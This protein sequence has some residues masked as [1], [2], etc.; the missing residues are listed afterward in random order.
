MTSLF[1]PDNSDQPPEPLMAV[2]PSDGLSPPTTRRPSTGGVH[3][4]FTEQA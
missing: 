2:H 1:R 3:P 4:A